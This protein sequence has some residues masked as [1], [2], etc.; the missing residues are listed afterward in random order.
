M[1]VNGTSEY[2]GT[3]LTEGKVMM[4]NFLVLRHGTDEGV[5]ENE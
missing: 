2:E 4:K 5:Y 1:P 3:F